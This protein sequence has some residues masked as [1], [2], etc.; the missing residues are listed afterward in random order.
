MK[1]QLMAR[2]AIEVI[3]DE[4][5]TVL[6]HHCEP[7]FAAV[8]DRLVGQNIAG[9]LLLGEESA[10]R[11]CLAG[12]ATADGASGLDVVAFTGAR[13][14]LL[15][16]HILPDGERGHR[17]WFSADGTLAGFNGVLRAALGAVHEWNNAIGTIAGF[18]DLMKDGGLPADKSRRYLER[19]ETAV[20]EA[21][22]IGEK[23]SHDMRRLAAETA[24]AAT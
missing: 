24:Q 11:R 4:S 18:A 17:V 15:R 23:L 20:R 14:M 16:F 10:L 19:I 7:E 2:V 21:R 5:G 13:P 9:S 12:P 22:A 6:R 1:D 8:A 3:L